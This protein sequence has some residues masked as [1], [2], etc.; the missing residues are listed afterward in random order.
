MAIEKVKKDSTTK[1]TI[2]LMYMPFDREEVENKIRFQ[3]KHKTSFDFEFV[4]N[5]KKTIL[6]FQIF[7]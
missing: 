2:S 4:T 5:D 7:N 6:P 1:C 3:K